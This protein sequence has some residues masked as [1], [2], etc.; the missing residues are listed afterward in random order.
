MKRRNK[1]V[2]YVEDVD[3]SPA[4]FEG[5]QGRIGEDVEEGARLCFWLVFSTLAAL[6][7]VLVIAWILR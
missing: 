2:E 7:F 5:G 4:G 6:A 3:L 1:Y